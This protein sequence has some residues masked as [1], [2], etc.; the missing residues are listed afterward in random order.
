MFAEN[1]FW[2][3]QVFGATCEIKE[4]INLETVTQLTCQDACEERD[5]CVGIS[6]YSDSFDNYDCSYLCYESLVL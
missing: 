5:S 3:N 6:C 1:N 2:P 4:H